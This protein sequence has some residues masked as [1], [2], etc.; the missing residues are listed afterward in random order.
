M[1][2]A[3]IALVAAVA[4]NGVIGRDNALP[5]RLP[6][7]MRHFRS[8]TDGKPVLLGR[9][10]WQSIGR[11]LPGRFVIVLSADLD[12]RPDGVELARTPL[13]GLAR[14]AA[15][16]RR[17]AASEI[18]VAG[19]AS[20]YETLIGQAQRLHVTEV[21]LAPDGDTRFP[22]ID[23]HLWIETARAHHPRGDRDDASF[24]FVT[25]ARR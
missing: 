14:A 8:I 3:P 5:W 23:P 21:D 24:A 20:L 9:K 4:R 13:E 7:D 17:E 25:Y 11:P 10:T 6:G 18:V 16:A 19:V 1:S 15:I 22:P 2:G 12:Y